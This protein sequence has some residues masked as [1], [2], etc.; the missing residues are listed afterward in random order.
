[1]NLRTCSRV[2]SHPYCTWGTCFTYIIKAAYSNML[3]YIAERKLNLDEFIYPLFCFFLGWQL[4]LWHV[5]NG[6]CQWVCAG[7]KRSHQVHLRLPNHHQWLEGWSNPLH[8][9]RHELQCGRIWNDFATEN[10]LLYC[11]I[12]PTLGTICSCFLDQLSS[13]SWSHSRKDD[14]ASHHLSRPYQ[15]L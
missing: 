12:L 7:W 15:Y 1:M 3:Q 13:Q 11:H 5:Q 4:Q 2:Y 9:T 8:C 6:L 14:S 10:V